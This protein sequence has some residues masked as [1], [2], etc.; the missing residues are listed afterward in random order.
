MQKLFLSLFILLSALLPSLTV[1]HGLG[2]SLEAKSGDYIV[3][4]DYDNLAVQI[5]Q[6]TRFN[7]RMLNRDGFAVIFDAAQFSL[8]K[9]EMMLHT[10]TLPRA[11]LGPTGTEYLFT[12]SGDYTINVSFLKDNQEIGKAN[13]IIQVQIP[14]TPLIEWIIEQQHKIIAGSVIIGLGLISY[15]YFTRSKNTQEN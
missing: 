5:H 7:V 8:A 9:D 3:D 14:N 15:V 11:K 6:P 10:K 4:V 2:I 1:A 13:F 12:D